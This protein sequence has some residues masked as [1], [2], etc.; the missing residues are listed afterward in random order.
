MA[1]AP[2][3][4]IWSFPFCTRRPLKCSCIHSAH[5]VHVPICVHVPMCACARYQVD[6][7]LARCTWN[8]HTSSW[9]VDGN[10]ALLPSENLPIPTGPLLTSSTAF[11]SSGQ[12]LHYSIVLLPAPVLLLP[13][14]THVLGQEQQDQQQCTLHRAGTGPQSWQLQE[15]PMPG[16]VLG[17]LSARES[18]VLRTAPAEKGVSGTGEAAVRLRL[19]ADVHG[20]GDSVL[21][22]WQPH[23]HTSKAMMD[24]TGA[25][26]AAQQPQTCAA[27]KA[28]P[29]VGAIAE[30]GMDF[31]LVA[32]AG[33]HFVP[34]DIIPNACAAK[35]TE[36]TACAATPAAKEQPRRVEVRLC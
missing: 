13:L 34:L 3:W 29:S 20:L 12:P 25:A 26:P 10:C 15:L 9:T 5:H 4:S 33:T 11:S 2:G 21:T 17:P 18:C 14:M 6:G 7:L 30:A 35:G 16:K 27:S 8:A 36:E 19:V 24:G 28:A 1:S 22:G 23:R 32:R 31:Q